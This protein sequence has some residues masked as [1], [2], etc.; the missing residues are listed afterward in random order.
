[1]NVSITSSWS[2]S[3]GSLS[4]TSVADIEDVELGEISADS[5]VLLTP[6]QEGERGEL[7]I[8]GPV[9]AVLLITDSPR[10]EVLANTGYL[11]SAQGRLG[12]LKDLSDYSCLGQLID[13]AEDSN[14][15]SVKIV[16]KSGS[17]EKVTLRLP[18][19]SS[20]CWIYKASAVVSREPG[21]PPSNL[22]HFDLQNINSLLP[23]SSASTMSSGR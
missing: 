8:T 1:M 5:C 15:Y 12:S 19:A 6:G 3:N 7:N 16:L 23:T 10:W 22:G 18:P 14:I 9:R 11:F 20:S 17:Y 13:E 2:Q 4:L 21:P